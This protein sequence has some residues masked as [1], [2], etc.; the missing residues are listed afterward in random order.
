MS[1]DMAQTR[2]T[3]SIA[4]TLADYELH[5]S[6]PF[7]DTTSLEEAETNSQPLP[8]NSVESNPPSWETAWRRVPPHRPVNTELDMI[9]RSTT[10]NA[11]ETFFIYNMFNGI[12][13]VEV[14]V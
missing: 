1:V 14:C 4:R 8:G 9:S 13:L 5:H 7:R 12:R 3:Y 2:V 10:L 6:Q 11:V